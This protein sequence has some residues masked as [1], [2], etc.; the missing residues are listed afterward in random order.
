MLVTNSNTKSINSIE[1]G[2]R[3][4]SIRRAASSCGLPVL[5]LREDRQTL[6]IAGVLPD[7]K[8]CVGRFARPYLGVK[9]SLIQGQIHGQNR[10]MP[11]RALRRLGDFMKD[12]T[13]KWTY[14]KATKCWISECGSKI[15][16]SGPMLPRYCPECGKQVILEDDDE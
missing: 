10:K 5:L 14:D 1:I 4:S 8:P 12:E 3:I 16:Y 7:F 11:V 6:P 2:V 9:W 15:P 13:C